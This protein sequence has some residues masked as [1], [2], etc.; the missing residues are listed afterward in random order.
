MSDERIKIFKKKISFL[1]ID[2]L[3][4]HKPQQQILK[5]FSYFSSI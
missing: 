1:K 5:Y 2:K 4:L 3:S